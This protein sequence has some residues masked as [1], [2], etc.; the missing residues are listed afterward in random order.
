MTA[1]DHHERRLRSSELSSPST[2]FAAANDD[3][4]KDSFDERF[5]SLLYLEENF[6]RIGHEE[7]VRD[8]QERGLREGE[9]IGF[10]KGFEIGSELGHYRGALKVWMRDCDCFDRDEEFLGEEWPG[11][12][13]RRLR[14][15]V[16]D[17]EDEGGSSEEE[18]SRQ[19]SVMNG[20]SEKGKARAR[21]A[22]RRLEDAIEQIFSTKNEDD[23]EASERRSS[24]RDADKEDDDD[25]DDNDDLSY[26]EENLDELLE[27]KMEQVRASF[28]K[29]TASLGVHGKYKGFV[30]GGSNGEDSGVF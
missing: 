22:M 6:A 4:D 23:G 7:G 27:E 28:R 30:N 29:C 17:V 18:R 5:E 24:S 2:T 14:S 1:R 26:G 8:G 20:F 3:D 13:R 10:L 11:Q 25:D 21:E 19:L 15:A 12:R 9:V 16:T